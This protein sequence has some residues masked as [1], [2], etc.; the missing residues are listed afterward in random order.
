[1]GN[2]CIPVAD[3]FWYMAKQYNIVKLNKIKLKKTTTKNKITEHT[4]FS[5]LCGTYTH[6]YRPWNHEIDPNSWDAVKAVLRGKFIALSAYIR[7]EESLKICDISSHLRKQEKEKQFK[8]K[9]SR[10]NKTKFWGRIIEIEN[11]KS[12]GKMKKAIWMKLMKNWTLV[13]K[14]VSLFKKKKE[15]D[16]SRKRNK[17]NPN[18]KRRSK[19]LTV[20]RWHDPLHRKP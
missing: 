1:M 15:L 6:Q 2:T 20:C 9:A 3:S 13:N 10:K 7:K 5:M 17:R 14:I 8:T 11:R 18:W 12:M 19:T 4:F 16:M